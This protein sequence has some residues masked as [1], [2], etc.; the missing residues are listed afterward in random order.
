MEIPAI[1]LFGRGSLQ[2]GPS[3]AYSACSHASAARKVKARGGSDAPRF[4]LRALGA[5]SAGGGPCSSFDDQT[6]QLCPQITVTF[7]GLLIFA[8]FLASLRWR[9][10]NLELLDGPFWPDLEGHRRPSQVQRHVVASVFQP[11]RGRVLRPMQVASAG[12]CQ[13]LVTVASS[14]TAF[15][16]GVFG[17]FLDQIR[18]LFRMLKTRRLFTALHLR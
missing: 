12:G 16:G 1:P 17:D 7:L 2:F 10:R 3:R 5:G 8:P 9:A 11:V 14:L 13:V 4:G 18:W 15:G 6:E